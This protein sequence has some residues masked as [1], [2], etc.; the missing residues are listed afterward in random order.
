[1]AKVLLGKEVADV[2]TEELIERVAKLK[3]NGVEPTLAIVRLGAEADDLSYERGALKRAE[4]VGVKV[5]VHEL[6]RDLSQEDLEQVILDINAD[7]SVHGCLVF[8][9]LP[10][11][12]DEE[13]IGAMLASKK[14]I[15]GFTDGSLAG[16]FKGED[17][18][19]APCTA[20][21]AIAI[22][23]HYNVNL[24][25]ARAVVLGRSLVIGKP[26]AMML[27]QENSTVTICH[28]RTKEIAKAAKDA[29]V[30]IAAVGQAKMVTPEFCNPGQV[31]IDVG[32]NVD[33]EG[34]LLGDVDYDAVEP[35]VKAITPVPR[36]VGSVTTSILMKHVVEAAERATD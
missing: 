22:L 16:V 20:E 33:E 21:A 36:G 35:L 32:I 30:L 14:D 5:N 25:G 6:A 11:Q 1:M 4:R 28:S 17:S 24:N 10:Q 2:L 15:D 23:K 19:F 26:V 27:L 31:I 12:I 18:G 34:K 8:R 13:K 9:P 29:D 3:D 7:D